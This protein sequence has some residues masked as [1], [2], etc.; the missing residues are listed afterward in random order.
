MSVRHFLLQNA[1][2]CVLFGLGL[3]AGAISNAAYASDN[4]DLYDKIGCYYYENYAMQICED[5]ER[6][7][8]SEAAAAV[9]S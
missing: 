9:S 3:L 6:V 8:T 2:M 5:I 1:I 4:E 7:Y